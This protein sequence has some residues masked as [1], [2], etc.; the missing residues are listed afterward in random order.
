MLDCQIAILENAVARLQVSGTSPGPL[1][2]RHP[3]ITP[4]QAFQCA[5]RAIVMCVLDNLVKGA[6]GQAIQNMNVMCGFP[7]TM[8]IDQVGV[9]P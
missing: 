2:S 5:D 9:F 4:F 6:S 3:S 1:G 8:G 7:E